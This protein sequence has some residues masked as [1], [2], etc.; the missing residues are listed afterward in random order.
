MGTLL[1]SFFE[2]KTMR[3]LATGESTGVFDAT[4]RRYVQLDGN[5]TYGQ[6]IDAVYANLSHGYRNEYFYK[7]T[8]F[9]KLL[10]RRH[11]PRTTVSF[12][13][14]PIGRAKADFVMI[15]GVGRVYEIKTEL[16]NLSRL[17]HQ[18][19]EYYKAF[20]YVSI[21]TCHSYLNEVMA[22][23]PRETGIIEL[24][25]RGALRD[26]RKAIPVTNELDASVMFRMLRKAEYDEILQR[27]FHTLPE[28]DDFSAYRA[29][30][31]FFA[32]L[33]TDIC[34]KELLCALKRRRPFVSKKT[35]LDI[36][37]A[38]RFLLYDS[39]DA[40]ENWRGLSHIL[41]E[42]YGG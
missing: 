30:K 36:P 11:D 10:L 24:T 18:I 13:E 9:N 16:D 40:E 38:L 6:V 21:V 37:L 8:L 29:S 32:T 2:K 39:G 28:V 25:Q 5:E 3:K 12:S 19:R 27:R 34:Q 14:L 22:V 20:S 7:N 4:A 41:Q 17:K 23:I 15:N 42:T 26:W 1:Q 35:L 31:K 33:G